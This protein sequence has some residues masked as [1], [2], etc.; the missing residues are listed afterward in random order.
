MTP[1]VARP[2]IPERTPWNEQ[3]PANLPHSIVLSGAGYCVRALLEGRQPIELT[4]T[5][6]LRLSKDLP[7]DWKEQRCFLC[8]AA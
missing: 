1:P 4:P 2:S 6:L 3:V 7:H 8:F 5:R